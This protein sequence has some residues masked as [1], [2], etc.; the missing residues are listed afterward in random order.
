MKL[1]PIIYTNEAAKTPEEAIKAELG[2]FVQNDGASAHVILL[3]A[4]RCEAIVRSYQAKGMKPTKAKSRTPSISSVTYT[5]PSSP[6]VQGDYDPSVPPWD[7]NESVAGNKQEW[8]TIALGNRAIVGG[9]AAER[10]DGEMWR[11]AYSVAVEKYGPMLYEAM[12]GIIYPDYLRSDYS[13]TKD[14][15]TIWN[16][17]LQ[18]KDVKAVP[19][20]EL[21]DDAWGALTTSFNVAG[22]TSAAAKKAQKELRQTGEAPEGWF[23]KFVA[24]LP[25]EDKEKLGPFYAYQK[26][27]GK[28]LS[29]YNTLFEAADDIVRM[30]QTTLKLSEDDI[31]NAINIASAD[32]FRRFY[33]GH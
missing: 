11:V 22:L 26:K 21:S 15:Q 2:L 16:K 3:S 4:E 10:T 20:D 13:L 23:N 33:K 17:M 28:N 27:T 19:V 6:I 5:Q 24:T 30:F 14:S 18:R 31:K 25:P 12:M 29:K 32:T 8:L 9:V 1:Y 7:I